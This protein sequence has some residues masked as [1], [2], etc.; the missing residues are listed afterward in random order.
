ML[1]VIVLSSVPV[2][3]YCYWLPFV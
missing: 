2:V 3:V 1:F